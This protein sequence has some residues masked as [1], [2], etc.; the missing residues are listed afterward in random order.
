MNKSHSPH[1]PSHGKSTI[2]VVTLDGP[3]GVGKSTLAQEVAKALSIGYLDTGAMF[4]TLA[5]KTLQ[6]PQISLDGDGSLLLK[7]LGTLD[8][9]LTTSAQGSL[10]LCNGEPI[11]EAIRSEEVAA[12]AARIASLPAI[13]T[14]LKAT[15]QHI[16]ATTSLVA[17]GRDMGTVVFPRAP[18]KF[19][20][21][22]SVAVRA[23]RRYDQ[24]MT[25]GQKA[26][27]EAIAEQI[28]RR[29]EQD[30]NR[31]VAPLVP[32]QDA[33]IIDTSALTIDEVLARILG[34]CPQS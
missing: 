8:F 16:G 25:M 11:S 12:Q 31:P 17:E 9:T 29:D 30:R 23:K 27:L 15:Q 21:D 14:F 32:A 2:L 10:L 24:L 13:R 18:Y 33:I 19:F 34:H 5:L 26:D 6:V 3:A 22:A 4:R 20:L 28:R 1:T 7:E